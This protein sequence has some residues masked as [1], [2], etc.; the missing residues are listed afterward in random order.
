[1]ETSLRSKNFDYDQL[2]CLSHHLHLHP[3]SSV[4]ALVLDLLA[5]PLL[6]TSPQSVPILQ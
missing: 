2:P 1:M 3:E 4:Q 5:D 6:D